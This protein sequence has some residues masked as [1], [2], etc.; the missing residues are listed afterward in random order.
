[1]II[2]PQHKGKKFGIADTKRESRHGRYEFFLPT[3]S[4]RSAYILF[5]S[6]VQGNI[7]DKNMTAKQKKMS[8]DLVSL[9][10][11][12]DTKGNG[13]S[14]AAKNNSYA[15]FVKAVSATSTIKFVDELLK[16]NP[17]LSNNEIGTQLGIHLNKK[18][19][20]G[21]MLRYATAICSYRKYILRPSSK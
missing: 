16:R 1:M 8:F 4:P 18:W 3:S 13:I 11:M 19:S 15:E 21:T 10:L 17:S 2:A 14:I 20:E 12:S 6:I 7:T 9:G 5:E